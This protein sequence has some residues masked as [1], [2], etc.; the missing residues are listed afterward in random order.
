MA[1]PH[2]SSD[3]AVAFDTSRLSSNTATGVKAAAPV[4]FTDAPFQFG[5]VP[6]KRGNTVLTVTASDGTQATLK[7]TG[8]GTGMV[9]LEDGKFLID[10]VGTRATSAFEIRSSGPGTVGKPGVPV[11]APPPLEP[12]PDAPWE[13]INKTLGEE[14]ERLKGSASQVLAHQLA[15]L[16]DFGF[17][18]VQGSLYVCDNEDM[19]N[20]MDALDALAVLPWFPRSVRNIR[21]FRVEQ[22]SDFTARIKRKAR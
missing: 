15:T 2:P 4:K 8:G 13:D 11:S 16:A 18:R 22:R 19:A 9:R 10:L 21:A 12:P 7:L 5:A 14:Y 17:R 3:A 20:L 1:A 6:G